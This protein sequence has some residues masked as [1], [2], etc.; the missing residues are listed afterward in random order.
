MAVLDEADWSD[1]GRRGLQPVTF[2]VIGSPSLGRAFENRWLAP[3]AEP[4]T[5]R[6]R[7]SCCQRQR[8]HLS[9][10]PGQRR[11]DIELSCSELWRGRV[12]ELSATA[13]AHDSA[14]PNA[15]PSTNSRLR[16]LS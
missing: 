2:P 8:L 10:Q 16:T 4:G 7:P 12:I 11:E 14:K 5:L 13:N 6:H 1:S 15:D 3:L 9:R